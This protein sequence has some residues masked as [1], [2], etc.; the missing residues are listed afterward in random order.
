MDGLRR[1]RLAG[2]P[3]TEQGFTLIEVMVSAVILLLVF[4]GLAN[5]F[6]MSRRQ[7]VQEEDRRN[8]TAVAQARLETLRRD[9]NNRDLPGLAGNDTT[10]VVDGRDFVVSHAVAADTPENRATTVTVM[11]SWSSNY[12]G[13][14]LNRSLDC[15]TILGRSSD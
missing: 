2:K 3:G 13:S 11:V 12:S 14:I 8:A 1:K 5:V 15:T 4:F 9:Y 10:Y 7:L 6:S